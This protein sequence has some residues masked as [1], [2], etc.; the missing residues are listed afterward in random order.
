MHAEELNCGDENVNEIFETAVE[1]RKHET[2]IPELMLQP[3]YPQSP[4]LQGIVSKQKLDLRLLHPSNMNT[5]F[6]IQ[7]N[8]EE[9]K[10]KHY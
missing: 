9:V 8:S 5:V 3:Y 6:E 1:W 10:R 4:V 2:S 7:E